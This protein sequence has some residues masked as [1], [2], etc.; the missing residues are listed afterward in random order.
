[1]RLTTGAGPGATAAL[2][3][4]ALIGFARCLRRS[5][6]CSP[7]CWWRSASPRSS[8]RL[9]GYPDARQGGTA[10]L[11][12]RPPCRPAR[13]AGTPPVVIDALAAAIKKIM[14]EPDMRAPDQARLHPSSW[15]Q[16]GRIRPDDRPPQRTKW[17]ERHRLRRHQGATRRASPPG[18]AASE[19]LAAPKD[20]HDQAQQRYALRSLLHCD[21]HRLRLGGDRL[22]HR[23][24]PAHGAG[25]L[26]A[27]GGLAA[28]GGSGLL[29]VLRDRLAT[30]RAKPAGAGT[31]G[32]W[33]PSGCGCSPGCCSSARPHRARPRAFARGHRNGGLACGPQQLAPERRAMPRPDHAV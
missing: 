20:A 14:A 17:R 21:R 11:R 1:M 2:S 4:E 29:I 6:T 9:P 33:G 31:A 10:R 32:R 26:P 8:R 24:T 5:S 3:N 16:P 23:H 25:V 13:P 27:A 7:A 18:P 28:L 22:R 30:A 19:P 15:Q 12:G